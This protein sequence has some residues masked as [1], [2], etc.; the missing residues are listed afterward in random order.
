[1]KISNEFPSNY[2]RAQDLE[3]RPATVVISGVESEE[4]GTEKEAK[5]VLYFKGKS[6]GVILNKTN[7]TAIAGLYGDDTDGWS[8]ESITLFAAQVSFQG[9]VVDAI[10]VKAPPR[11]T[12]KPKTEAHPPLNNN[13]IEDSI[14]F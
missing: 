2:L 1:M 12:E 3:G 9:K 11:K 14:P 8:G 7:A 4:V 6:K 13:E 5:P 10:R